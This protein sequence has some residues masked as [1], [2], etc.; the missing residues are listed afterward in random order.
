MSSANVGSLPRS[1]LIGQVD[2][3]TVF[4][5]PGQTGTTYEISHM[6]AKTPATD[7][8]HVVLYPD[9]QPKTLAESYADPQRLGALGA[10]KHEK[11]NAIGLRVRRD[12]PQAKQVPVAIR[13]THASL[14]KDRYRTT[15]IESKCATLGQTGSVLHALKWECE[16]YHAAW[17]P[18]TASN[19]ALV[20]AHDPRPTPR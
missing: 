18:A 7:D 12:S 4:K 11:A 5:A 10:V 1:A 15:G 14:A 2:L 8:Y 3:L 19:F 6:G 16:V 13:G 17:D 20:R 9:G